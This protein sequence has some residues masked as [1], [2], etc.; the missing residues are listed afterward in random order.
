LKTVLLGRARNEN[1]MV[2]WL[3]AAVIGYSYSR[4][5]A[6]LWLRSRWSPRPVRR[7]SGEPI[8][9]AVM[10]VRNEEAAIAHKLE[11]C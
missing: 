11:T 6:W 1:E 2:F 7:G 9:S 5:P 3:A 10:V 8:G 4:Y